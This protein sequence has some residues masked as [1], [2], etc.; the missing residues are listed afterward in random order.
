VD[1]YFPAGL[2][3]DME[4]R[5]LAVDSTAGG[6]YKTLSTPLT[7]TNV[8]VLGGHVLP[9]QQS[10]MTTTVGRAS[11]FTLVAALDSAGTA[12]GQLFW[13][14]GEQITI[15]D[16]LE[17]TYSAQVAGAMGSLSATLQTASYADASSLSITSVQVLGASAQPTSVILN[18]TPLDD[19]QISFDADKGSLVFASLAIKLTDAFELTWK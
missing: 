12:S 15:T 16:Y 6:V 1:A 8:H 19:V 5:S 3:Y 7:K 2:W 14:D 17:V 11:P 4:T 10:A 13:D 18:G 9:L